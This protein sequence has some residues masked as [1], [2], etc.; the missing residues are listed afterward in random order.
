[1]LKSLLASPVLTVVMGLFAMTC[2]AGERRVLTATFSPDKK[3]VIV[4]EHSEAGGREGENFYFEE[5]SSHKKLGAVLPSS[6][7]GRDGVSKVDIVT[8]WN[9]DGSNVALLVFYGEKLNELLIDTRDGAG[10]FQ[11]VD[12]QEPD[13][14]AVYRQRTGHGLPEGGDGFSENAVGPWLDTDTVRLVSGASR[15]TT[16]PDEYIHVFVTFTARIQGRRAAIF[17]SRFTGPLS[18]TASDRFE[19]KWGKRYFESGEGN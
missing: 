9:R 1:M 6:Q 3:T 10:R 14:E 17:E 19:Q 4:E 12:L 2:R 16:T 7:R 11:P 8:S 5:S 18:N 13:A 15:Q